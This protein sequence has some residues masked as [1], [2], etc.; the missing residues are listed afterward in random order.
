MAWALFKFSVASNQTEEVKEIVDKYK[1]GGAEGRAELVKRFG[2]ARV[3]KVVE[4]GYSMELIENTSKQCPK[5]KSWMQK[6]DGCNKMTCA[7]C[8]CYF[9]W[10]CMAVLSKNDP[11]NHFTNMGS[12]CY[13]RLFEGIDQGQEDV[14]EGRHESGDE[15]QFEDVDDDED[16]DFRVVFQDSDEEL[17]ELIAQLD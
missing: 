2:E 14:D 17:A 10:L 16:D 9:C 11:Y 6:L 13:A 15:D 1:N 7:K 5:C 3:K 4:E 12:A 8:H